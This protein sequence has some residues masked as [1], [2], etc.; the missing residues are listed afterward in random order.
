MSSSSKLL[1]FIAFMIGLNIY[2]S[3]LEDSILPEVLAPQWIVLFTWVSGAIMC[4][5]PVVY[6]ICGLH[7][8]TELHGGN[9]RAYLK[10]DIFSQNAEKIRKMSIFAPLCLF[11]LVCVGIQYEYYG[12]AC[13]SFVVFVGGLI[14]RHHNNKFFELYKLEKLKS[15]AKEVE[16]Q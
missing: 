7:I 9:D 11:V 16:V 13:A 14:I 3:M 15:I 4:V 8:H 10:H 1:M 12:A 5:V 2:T 6:I